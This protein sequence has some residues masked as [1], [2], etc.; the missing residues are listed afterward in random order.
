MAQGRPVKMVGLRT[1]KLTLYSSALCICALPYLYMHLFRCSLIDITGKLSF[2][3]ALSVSTISLVFSYQNLA[4]RRFHQLQRRSEVCRKLD[5][6]SDDVI[7]LQVTSLW[8][9]VALLNSVFVTIFFVLE[10]YILSYLSPQK[11]TVY[12]GINN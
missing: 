2:L 6:K 10:R 11:Y 4:T 12:F 3:L 9:A 5:K 1:Y 8:Y 7:Q